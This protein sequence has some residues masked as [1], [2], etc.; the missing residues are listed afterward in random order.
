MGSLIDKTK[1]PFGKW[2]RD[3]LA[4]HIDFVNF[5]HKKGYGLLL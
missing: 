3:V 1:T 2:I 4:Y 5:E